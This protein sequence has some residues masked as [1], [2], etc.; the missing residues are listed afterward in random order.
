MTAARARGGWGPG[1]RARRILWAGAGLFGLCVVVLGA[2]TINYSYYNHRCFKANQ[3]RGCEEFVPMET[4]V[5]D[6][7]VEGVR[8]DRER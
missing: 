8:I 2:W 7:K 6:H 1:S 3:W 4:W 5:C